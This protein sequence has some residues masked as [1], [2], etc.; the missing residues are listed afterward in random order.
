MQV[1][2]FLSD[3]NTSTESC[4]HALVCFGVK[5]RFLHQHHRHSV[6]VTKIYLLVSYHLFFLCTG[7]NQH[8]VLVES[9]DLVQWNHIR[10]YLCQNRTML[11]LFSHGNTFENTF[12]R[13]RALLY[14][15]S[16]VKF[17]NVTCTDFAA[18]FDHQ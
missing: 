11:S 6:K 4:S 8:T 1:I 12:P 15:H 3:S 16:I 17:W 18:R 13:I 10:R 2:M 7:I 5:P 14:F 9:T